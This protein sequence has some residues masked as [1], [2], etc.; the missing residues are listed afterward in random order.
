MRFPDSS[1]QIGGSEN[2][3]PAN[4]RISQRASGRITADS[5]RT[6]ISEFGVV[7]VSVLSHY[8]YLCRGASYQVAGSAGA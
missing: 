2:Q 7:S 3:C 5:L 4:M 8:T 6:F 1:S